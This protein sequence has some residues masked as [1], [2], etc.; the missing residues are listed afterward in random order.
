MAYLT[1]F[2]QDQGHGSQG[3]IFLSN[4]NFVLQPLSIVIYKICSAWTTR[5]AYVPLVDIIEMILSKIYA[6]L[7]A[8]AINILYYSR[9]VQP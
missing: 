1:L 2:Y 8:T 5:K 6:S 7:G 3:S 4:N 9:I